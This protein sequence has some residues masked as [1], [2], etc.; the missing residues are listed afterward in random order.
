MFGIEEAGKIIELPFGDDPSDLPLE[1][2]ADSIQ[3]DLKEMLE[4][5]TF[6]ETDPEDA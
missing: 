6:L 3:T 5:Q 4:F 1:K 2:Y